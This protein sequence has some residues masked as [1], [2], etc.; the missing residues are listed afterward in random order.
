M[1]FD[2]AGITAWDSGLVTFVLKLL[3]EV[4]KLG[5]DANR[6]GLPDGVQRLVALAE[7][8]PER[9]T[10]RSGAR[11]PWLARIGAGQSDITLVGGAQNS[12]RREMLML[13][14]F[15]GFAL[16]GA[17]HPV[18]DRADEPGF[19]LGS[20]GAFLVLEASEHARA[21]GAKPLARLV[22]VVN[23]RSNRKPGAVTTTSAVRGQFKT[24][25]ASRAEALDL[26]L[27]K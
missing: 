10:G 24:S 26:I 8:V 4:A 5:V 18:W 6:D 17:F 2:A 16:K 21:R 25:A 27:R 19:A 12:E 20:M 9:E 11:P 22:A 13:Y 3:R 1:A 7:A 14:E 15:G 23:A